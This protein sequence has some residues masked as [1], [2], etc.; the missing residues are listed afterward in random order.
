M[1][2]TDDKQHPRGAC[3]FRA[4]TL[5]E[6]LVVI[7]ILVLLASLLLPGLSRAKARS[8]RVACL[9]N[10]RQLQLASHLYVL[11][12]DDRLPPYNFV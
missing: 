9:S 5:I 2:A 7:T 11:D 1:N 10:M 6:L 8:H 3:G 12:H 4:F